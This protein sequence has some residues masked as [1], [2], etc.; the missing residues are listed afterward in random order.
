[1]STHAHDPGAVL[2]AGPDLSHTETVLATA[3]VTAAARAMS[4]AL[5]GPEA[6]PPWRWRLVAPAGALRDPGP[7]R[8]LEACGLAPS[9]ARALARRI[10]PLVA[11]VPPEALDPGQPV[12]LADTRGVPEP[13]CTRLAMLGPLAVEAALALRTPRPVPG[14]DIVALVEPDDDPGPGPWAGM[15]AAR[16][17]PPGLPE[18]SVRDV[19][20]AERARFVAGCAGTADWLP[21]AGESTV[22]LRSPAAHPGLPLAFA[23]FTVTC[24]ATLRALNARAGSA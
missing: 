18:R 8:L 9:T 1:M 11:A 13:E 22:A 23:P 20:A 17:D 4:H 7:A 6:Q 14:L 15:L 21:P 3:A 5:H 24:A 16:L 2:L 19:L 10:A 12:G